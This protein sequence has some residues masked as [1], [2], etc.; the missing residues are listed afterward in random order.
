MYRVVE[1]IFCL[2]FGYYRNGFMVFAVPNNLTVLRLFCDAVYN[3]YCF[4]FRGYK[5]QCVHVGLL[6]C[7]SETRVPDNSFFF[8]SFI[9]FQPLVI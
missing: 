4:G 5:R 3:G 7:S 8:I 9:I 2:L 1:V 6:E